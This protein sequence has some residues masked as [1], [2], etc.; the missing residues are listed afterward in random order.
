MRV[1][2]DVA[3]AHDSTCGAN[4]TPVTSYKHMVS[5]KPG[6]LMIACA[7]HWEHLAHTVSD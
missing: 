7:H 5:D 6:Q 1:Y 2:P 4:R 3:G